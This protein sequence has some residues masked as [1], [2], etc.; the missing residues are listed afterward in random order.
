MSQVVEG[1]KTHRSK[2]SREL[3]QKYI[4]LLA[5]RL[6]GLSPLEQSELL[7]DDALEIA[8]F[9]GIEGGQ[10]ITAAFFQWLHQL[11]FEPIELHARSSYRFG[12]KL[13]PPP[14]AVDMLMIKGSLGI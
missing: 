7:E 12:W 3:R 5:S 10:S 13:P 2:K 14:R 9:R 4:C 8:F 1:L 11:T 6:P